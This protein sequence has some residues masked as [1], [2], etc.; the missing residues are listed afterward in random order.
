MLR[1]EER[2]QQAVYLQ[3]TPVG[4]SDLA[5]AHVQPALTLQLRETLAEFLDDLDTEF[6][7][8][9]TRVQPAR[10][11]LQDHLAD[12]RLSRRDRQSPAQRQLAAVQQRQPLLPA[13]DVLHMHP[14][15]VAG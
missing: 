3:E 2:R 9:I 14:A 15:H 6:I 4:E 8:E 13:I 1:L 10:L 5:L 12:E 7:A 11:Q